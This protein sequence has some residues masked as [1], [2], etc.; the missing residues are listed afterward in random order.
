M[1]SRLWKENYAVRFE[2]K[3]IKIDKIEICFTITFVKDVFNFLRCLFSLLYPY[4]IKT[5]LVAKQIIHIQVKK[6]ADK[7]VCHFDRVDY[8]DLSTTDSST[9]YL[10]G[11][12]LN[13]SRCYR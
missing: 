10:W 6:L 9:D 12:I 11:R 13:L 5:S 8:S 4:T 3:S 2:I 7:N 1:I